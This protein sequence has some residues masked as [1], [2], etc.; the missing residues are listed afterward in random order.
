MACLWDN[1]PPRNLWCF[2]QGSKSSGNIREFVQNDQSLQKTVK[3]CGVLIL[4]IKVT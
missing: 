2:K 3:I 1:V 4:R